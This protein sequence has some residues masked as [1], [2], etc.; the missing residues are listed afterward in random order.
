MNIF[1]LWIQLRELK[2]PFLTITE[3]FDHQE[4]STNPKNDD[5]RDTH[6][7]VFHY[8]LLHVLYRTPE[9]TSITRCLRGDI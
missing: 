9:S 2:A 6:N 8:S 1:P 4:E 3:L 5:K 7:K